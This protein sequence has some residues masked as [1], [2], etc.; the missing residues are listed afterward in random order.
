MIDPQD[1]G[2]FQCLPMP[3]SVY[4]K[5]IL[6]ISNAMRLPGATDKLTHYL[7]GSACYRIKGGS[8]KERIDAMVELSS[9]AASTA[10][11]SVTGDST[12]R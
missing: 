8:L 1:P 3:P 7:S 5:Q 6:P 11:V 4:L 10:V 9:K 2:E 12:G